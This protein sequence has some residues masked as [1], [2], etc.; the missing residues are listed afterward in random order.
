MLYRVFVCPL[1]VSYL[2]DATTGVLGFFLH[3][4]LKST[5]QFLRSKQM[6]NTR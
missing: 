2:A 6:L 5:E 4:Q 1:A 3:L